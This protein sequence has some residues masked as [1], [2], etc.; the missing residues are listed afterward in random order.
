MG[1]RAQQAKQRPEWE[2][3]KKIRVAG[4]TARQGNG[5]ADD[6][7]EGRTKA[8]WR[9]WQRAEEGDR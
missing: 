1:W 3:T 5:V 6:M 9:V 4:I 7:M 2:A 8:D